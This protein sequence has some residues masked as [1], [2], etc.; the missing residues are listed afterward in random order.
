VTPAEAQ[1]R[2]CG[3]APCGDSRKRAGVVSAA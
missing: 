2:G 3:G 1:S